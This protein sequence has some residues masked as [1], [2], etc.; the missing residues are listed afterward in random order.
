MNAIG[1]LQ[2]VVLEYLVSNEGPS[3]IETQQLSISVEKVSAKAL[4]ENESKLKRCR[5]KPPPGAAFGL[6]ESK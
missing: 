2:N 3:S 5:F 4:G 1:K 6:G